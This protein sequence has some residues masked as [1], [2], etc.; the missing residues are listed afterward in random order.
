MKATGNH[1]ILQT[2]IAFCLL[3]LSFIQTAASTISSI[4]PLQSMRNSLEEDLEN[5]SI[6]CYDQNFIP[7]YLDIKINDCQYTNKLEPYI[8]KMQ[9]QSAN[10]IKLLLKNGNLYSFR[11]FL[12]RLEL[13]LV[14]LSRF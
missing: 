4:H 5:S 13:F 11:V 2:N 7:V 10:R 12:A 3:A 14:C 8:R 9:G 1:K 6:V